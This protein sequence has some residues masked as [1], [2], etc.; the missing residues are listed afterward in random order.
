MDKIKK[1]VNRLINSYSI[2]YFKLHNTPIIDINEHK[3]EAVNNAI[4]LVQS[5][6]SMINRNEQI[7]LVKGYEIDD[8]EFWFTVIEDL[9]KY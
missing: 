6:I 7:Y 2:Y 5:Q 9:E 4:M 3:E 8:L 1:I